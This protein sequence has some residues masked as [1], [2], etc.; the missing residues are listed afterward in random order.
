MAVE[1]C[2]AETY[3][4]ARSAPFQRTTELVTR[5]VPVTVSVKPGPPAVAEV[6]VN[7]VEVGTGLLAAVIVN[8]CGLDVPPPGAGLKIVTCA[9]PAA[10]ISAAEIAAES[11]V[12]ETYVVARSVPF[13]RTTEL[14]TRFGPVTGRVTAARPAT[15]DAG[16]SPV[17][18]GAGFGCGDTGEFRSL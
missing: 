14:V 16:L 3:V 1:S 8:V 13:Q 2:V 15:A 17:V 5:F 4:V 10:A 11:C 7:P 9:V 18:V 6:G 12:A